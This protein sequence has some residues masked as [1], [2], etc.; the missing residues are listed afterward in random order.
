MRKIITILTVLMIILP[1]EG[2][3]LRPLAVRDRS[4]VTS[5]RAERFVLSLKHLNEEELIDLAQRTMVHG[6]NKTGAALCKQVLRELKERGWRYCFVLLS[7]KS[8]D[9]P[10]VQGEECIDYSRARVGIF[11]VS[12]V[13]AEDK[14]KFFEYFGVASEE[15]NLSHVGLDNFRAH[16]LTNILQ[17]A[18]EDICLYLCKPVVENGIDGLRIVAADK[19]SGFL[20]QRDGCGAELAISK[21]L[22]W[23]KNF[24]INGG[25]GT[26]LNRSLRRSSMFRILTNT[27]IAI[28]CHDSES[29]RF[30]EK[31]HLAYYDDPVLQRKGTIL[32][33]F[34]FQEQPAGEYWSSL[35]NRE[36]DRVARLTALGGPATSLAEIEWHAARLALSHV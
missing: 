21:A 14:I 15:I 7:D 5:S 36:N 9:F 18:R 12:G 22:K 32:D 19:G 1:R 27:E 25:A 29:Y 10:V 11:V 30:F 8:K 24:G 6:E 34:F 2:L 35:V 4:G 28:Y 13:D 3:C 33:A 31:D 20:D 26:G 17:H 23:K 16:T